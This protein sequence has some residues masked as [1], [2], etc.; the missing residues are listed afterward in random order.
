FEKGVEKG[1]QKGIEKGIQKGIEKGREEGVL[2]TARNFKALG[3]STEM[4]AQ[5]TGLSAAEIDAL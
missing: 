5:A 1:M 2:K 3:A 4:I